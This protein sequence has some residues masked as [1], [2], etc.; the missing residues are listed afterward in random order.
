MVQF[1]KILITKNKLHP[2]IYN[3]IHESQHAVI[4]FIITREGPDTYFAGYSE[5]GYPATLKAGYWYRISGQILTLYSN[6]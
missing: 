3:F 2:Q 5:A 6:D 1:E 4:Q